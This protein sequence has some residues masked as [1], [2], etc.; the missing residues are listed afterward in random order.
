[1][2]GQAESDQ[3]REDRGIY[4]AGGRIRRNNW[5]TEWEKKRLQVQAQ[6]DI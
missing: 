4:M 5:R 3:A 6:E 1:M 2:P